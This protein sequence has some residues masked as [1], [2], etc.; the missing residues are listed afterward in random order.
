MLLAGSTCV[1]DPAAI[2]LRM[3]QVEYTLHDWLAEHPPDDEQ[4][5]QSLAGIARRVIA[6]EPFRFAVRELLDEFGLLAND[7]QR[8]RSIRDE[9]Q[10]TAEPRYDAYLG[11]LAEHLAAKHSLARPEWSLAEGRFL[12]RFWFVS[13]VPGFRAMTIVE[14]PSAFRRRGIFISR[15]ALHRC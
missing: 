3:K 12:A 10:P 6:G 13:E 9:P 14:S 11:A 7:R 1:A 2:V 5:N 8:S 4:F 15:G